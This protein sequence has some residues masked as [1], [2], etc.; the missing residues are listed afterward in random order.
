M[1]FQAILWSQLR[2][3]S[4]GVIKIPTGAFA[5]SANGGPA[6]VVQDSPAVASI[7]GRQCLGMLAIDRAVKLAVEKAGSEG[8]GVVAINNTASTTGALGYTPFYGQTL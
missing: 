3:N 4:Q 8:V 7:D 6:V 2:G 1:H 5:H